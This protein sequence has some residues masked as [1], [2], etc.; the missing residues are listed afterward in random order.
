MV[1]NPGLLVDDK[2]E[3]INLVSSITPM[4][5][6]ISWEKDEDISEGNEDVPAFVLPSISGE[7][8]TKISLRKMRL[9]QIL[10]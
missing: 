6:S 10:L 9:I 2:F 1:N 8:K 4:L 5:P 3:P 7:K